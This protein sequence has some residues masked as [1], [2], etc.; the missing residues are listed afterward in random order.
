MCGR[1]KVDDHVSRR[2]PSCL[3]TGQET[4]LLLLLVS[5]L[6]DVPVLLLSVRQSRGEVCV[7][8]RSSATKKRTCAQR[9]SETDI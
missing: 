3:G 9:E 5:G 7:E 4:L 2:V 8:R 1:I 6:R